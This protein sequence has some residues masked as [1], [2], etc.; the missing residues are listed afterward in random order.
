MPIAYDTSGSQVGDT[1]TSRTV[2]LAA[3]GSDRIAIIATRWFTNDGTGNPT[4]TVN[5]SGAGV[6][7]IGSELQHS[8]DDRHR[9]TLHR[10]LAPSTS[11]V[12]YLATWGANVYSVALGVVTYTG[13]HQ[14]TPLAAAMDN[15]SDATGPATITVSS[16][17]GELVVAVLTVTSPGFDA[18]VTGG[19]TSRVHQNNWS[20]TEA[21]LD[22]AEEAGAASVTE[23]WSLSVDAKW[24][25]A[26][27][28]LAEADAAPPITDGP[29]LV[30]VRSN[31]RFN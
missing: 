1:V 20:G 12:A 9:M 29:A 19:Q 26:S 13:V 17:T 31:I 11:S 28:R 3:T 14:T 6:V 21:V 2:S 7:Q 27:I 15:A 25:I 18:T 23:S 30:S 24:E 22:M 10:L 4:I 16:A 5:G 8:A